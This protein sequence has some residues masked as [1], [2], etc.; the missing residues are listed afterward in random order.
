MKRNVL[1][2]IERLRSVRERLGKG[3][4]EETWTI[5]KETRQKSCMFA[6]LVTDR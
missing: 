6:I 4:G 5:E 1:K 3:T 2:C